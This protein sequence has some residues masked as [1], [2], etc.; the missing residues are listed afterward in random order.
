[1]RAA[2]SSAA[3]LCA[4][5]ERHSRY[6]RSGPQWKSKLAIYNRD[7]YITRGQMWSQLGKLNGGRRGAKT[8]QSAPHGS[9][10]CDEQSVC[11]RQQ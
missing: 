8:G 7:A 10:R 2:R 5:P 1:M 11:H 4:N 9:K 3:R 6:C